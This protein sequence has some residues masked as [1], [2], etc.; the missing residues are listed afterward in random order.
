VPSEKESLRAGNPEK[1][2]YVSIFFGR[3]DKIKSKDTENKKRYPVSG[4]NFI[5][6]P[7]SETM[8]IN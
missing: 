1:E 4:I 7:A 2:G 6:F 8:I 5:I 3:Q